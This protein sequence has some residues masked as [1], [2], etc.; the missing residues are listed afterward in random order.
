[1][2]NP[3]DVVIVTLIAAKNGA[4]V[5]Y[6]ENACSKS[7]RSCAPMEKLAVVQRRGTVGQRPSRAESCGLLSGEGKFRAPSH[8]YS[9]P[10]GG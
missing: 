6:T 4:P 2:L 8:R 5:G 9:A 1:M 3:G 7:A 10:L